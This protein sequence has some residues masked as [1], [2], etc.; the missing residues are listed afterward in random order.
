MTLNKRYSKTA[1]LVLCGLFAALIT[2]CSY[3][4]IPLPFTPVPINLGLLGVFL[5]GGLLGKKYGTISVLV[6]IIM[7]AAGLPVFSG[8]QGGLGVLAGPTGGFLLGYIAA[9]FIAGIIADHS[10]SA[11]SSR[12]LAL[13]TS[14]LSLGTIVCYIFGTL[15]F[16]FLMK[17]GLWPSLLACVFPFIPGDILKVIAGTI[18]LNRLHPFK[19]L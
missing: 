1:F 19:E 10:R 15:W 8:F 16:M 5:A 4:T 17:T 2:I 6:Y 11:E 9:A 14:A 12:K 3:I 18:L 13:Y 7:G